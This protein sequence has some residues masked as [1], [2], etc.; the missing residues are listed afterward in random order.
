[1]RVDVRM[2]GSEAQRYRCFLDGEEVT[3]RC[4]AADDVEGWAECYIQT[5][6]GGF[7]HVNGV[8]LTEKLKGNVVFERIEGEG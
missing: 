2:M 4:F 3:M 8:L 1:M 6:E 7:L 5:E